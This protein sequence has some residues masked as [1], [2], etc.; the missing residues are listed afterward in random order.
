M[1]LN[2][3]L[4]RPGGFPKFSPARFF[5]A[6]A[7]ILQL[8]FAGHAQVAGSIAV[9][10]E[11]STIEVGSTRQYSAYVPISPNTVTWK[12]NDTLG[13]DSVKGTVSATGLYKAPLV[14][15]TNNLIQIKVT[16]TAYPN[17]IGVATLKITRK[18]PWLWGASPSSLTPGNYT[19]SFNGSNFAPDSQALANGQPV[20]TTYVSPTKLIVQGVAQTGTI[21]FAVRQ[22]APGEVTGNT[23]NVQVAGTPVTVAVNPTFANVSLAASVPFS[24]TVTGNANTAVT[25]SVNGING[26]SATLGTITS[27]GIYTAPAVMPASNTVTVRATSVANNSSFAQSTVTLIALPPVTVAVS[28]TSAS[29]Q[30]GMSQPFGATVTGSPNTSVTWSVNSLNGGSATVGTI[31]AAGLYTAPAALPNGPI[32]V[33]ATSVANPTVFA[34]ANVTL[35]LPPPIPTTSLTAARFLEQATFGPSPSSLA[36]IQQLGIELWLDQQFAH[37]T[38]AIPAPANNSMGA[39]RQWMLHHYCTAPDQL[40][41]RVAYSL[42]QIIVTSANKLIYPNEMLPWLHILNHHAFGNYRDL[43]RDITKSPSMGKYLDLANSMKA[44]LAGGANENYGRELMQLFTIGLWKLKQNGSLQLD[45]ENH[46]I[47]TYEQEDVKEI[48]R[49]LTGWTYPTL[50]GQP[51]NGANWENFTGPMETRQ[52]F[53]DTGSKTFLGY[54]IP[55]GQTVEQDLESILDCLMTHTNTAPFV[56]TRLIR[57]LVM[58]NPSTNYIQRVAD[59]FVNNGSGVRGDLKA[60]VEA[61]LLDEEARNDSP[62]VNGGRVKEPILHLVGFLRALNGYFTSTHQLSYMFDYLAQSILA[63]PSVF[64]WFSP[65]YKV[66]KKPTLFGPEFQIYTASESTMRGNL[67]YHLLTNAGSDAVLDLAQFQ[68]YGSNLPAL[69]EMANQK[70]LY[71]RM[72]PEMKQIIINAAAPGYDANTRITTVLYLTALTGQYA[73][74][75]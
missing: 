37:P 12:V 72:T 48:S 66:P 34:T 17:S 15:P 23:V 10:P 28:P 61:I 57:S 4:P 64:N 46:P 26:G 50:P 30:L 65:L 53:H 47:P 63:P 35:T 39:L 74:Q 9:Y 25:W 13:G 73:V 20:Q 49:A 31:T 18:Y 24:A 14:A 7:A 38:N 41:Q 11:N 52:Q 55:A 70:F 59:V 43:L 6:L 45:A 2:Q 19:V 62:T 68:P 51:A 33:R 16:S 75:H 58:S 67:I 32:T 27:G 29:V 42:S 3:A 8:H 56:A 71:G 69:V 21:V 22:P 54:T 1:K 60:V 5:L 44:G 36:A 40:R